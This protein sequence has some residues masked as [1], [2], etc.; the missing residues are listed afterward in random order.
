MNELMKHCEKN[1]VPFYLE[2]PQR[3]KLWM[4]P[5]VKKWIQHKSSH[6]VEFDYCQF[7]TEWKKPT[8]ILSVGNAKSNTNSSI[9]C[10]TVWKDN[11]SLCS[12]TGKP[13]TT[14]SGFV[15]GAQKGQYKTN[16]A[17]PYPPDFCDHV[18]E[19]IYYPTLNYEK[20]SPQELAE[21]FVMA[22]GPAVSMQPPP[23]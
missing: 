19:L 8:T 20:K 1:D 11:V 9:R 16:R 10:K 23:P 21:R 6:K 17:C 5:I 7:G 18:A 13:H 4:H 2:N 12:K 3:S 22:I 14:L 15:N